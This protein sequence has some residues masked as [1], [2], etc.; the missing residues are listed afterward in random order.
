VPSQG[1]SV[2]LTFDP[3]P[4]RVLSPERAPASLMT[5]GQKAEAL[6]A[7]G[8]DVVAVLPFT[9]EIAALSPEAFARQVLREAVGARL[10]VVGTNF[11]F[12]KDRGGDLAE[13]RR[14]GQALGFEV[15]GVD[16]VL[17]EGV[18]ISST[19]VREALARGA[20]EAVLPLLGRPFFVDGRVVRGDGRGRTLGIPTANLQVENETI[21]RSGVYAGWVRLGGET[22]ARA[23]AVNVGR[24]PT[25]GGA[26]STVEAHLLD[27]DG[28]LYGRALRLSFVARIRDEQAFAEVAALVAQIKRDLEA[29]RALL[30]RASR[31]GV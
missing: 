5:V 30:E 25:F 29:T 28:D 11:R 18:P 12:G 22:G 13:L 26:L 14:L 10:V 15:E 7:L 16:P 4:S 2:V 19:R 31:D 9:A 20:V 21:P 6:F 8:V 27:F 23:A 1:R 17:H 24:R 3:H